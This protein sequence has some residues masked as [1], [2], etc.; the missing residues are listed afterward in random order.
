MTRFGDPDSGDAAPVPLLRSMPTARSLARSASPLN[1]SSI[2]MPVLG[3]V[4][5][6][7]GG[8]II[9]CKVHHIGKE[10]L[11]A[12]QAEWIFP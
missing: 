4:G 10:H 11:R 3:I 1:L 8:H 6:G 9:A 5:S 7:D 12:G 2:A